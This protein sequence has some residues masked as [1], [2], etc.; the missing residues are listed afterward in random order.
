LNSSAAWRR[1]ALVK[2]ALAQINTTV[3]DLA[4]NEARIRDAYAR[5]VAAGADRV[6]LPELAITGYPPRDLLLKRSFVERNLQT[7]ERLAAATGKTALVV[8]YVG[9]SEARPGR[10]LTNAVALAQNGKVVATRTKTLLPTYD[11]FD[12]DRYFEPAKENLPVD[13]GGK[14]IG[15]TICEDVWND[16]DFWRDRRYRSNPAVELASMGVKL[17]VNASASP[18][19]LGKNK[20]RREMLANLAAKTGC[21]L[22]Y[23]NLVGG[24]DEL[25]FDG[26]S[27]V[28]NARGELLA[29]GKM[30]EEDFLLV[31]LE[32]LPGA[33]ARL[34]RLRSQVRFQIGAARLERWN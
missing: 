23:C 20:L 9:R 31:D 34:A 3:G 10:E 11:V 13:F 8:G 19:H 28:F 12:E 16:E 26:A 17:L 4:G 2:V 27:V 1:L 29:E 24:N 32:T 25:V 7:L 33:R 21:P 6:V 15:L 22:V 18:W 30:F 14:K 5:A